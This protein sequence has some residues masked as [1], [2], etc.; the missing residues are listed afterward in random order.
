MITSIFL[1]MLVFRLI[2]VYLI[3][4]ETHIWNFTAMGCFRESAP[5]YSRLG[6]GSMLFLV[7]CSTMYAIAR[8]TGTAIKEA[9][10]SNQ[11]E[12]DFMVSFDL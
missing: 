3:C 2:A 7:A 11:L 12:A 9:R 6:Y 10:K 1:V 4:E 8:S 5:W